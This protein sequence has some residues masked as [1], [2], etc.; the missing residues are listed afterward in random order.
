MTGSLAVVLKGYPRLSETFIA[1]ELRALEIAG[2]RLTLFPMRQPHDGTTHPIHAEIEA[3]VRYLP[4]YLHDA[5]LRMMRSLW[6]ARRLPGFRSALAHLVSDLRHDL[7]R[8]RLRRFGQGAVLA[9][10]LPPD[11]T[12]IYAHFIH[13]PASV[14][15]YASLITG[16]PWMCSAHAKDIWTTPDRDLVQKLSG[17]R[18]TVTCTRSGHARLAALAPDPSRVHLMYHGLDLERF[19]PNPRPGSLRDGTVADDPVRL[20]SVG[21][22]VPKKG[23]DTLVAALARLPDDLHWHFT[24][25]GGGSERDRLIRAAEAAGIASRTTWAGAKD[26]PGVLQAYREADIFALPC[27]VTDSG[28]RDGLPNVLMEAQSQRLACVSTTVGGVAELVLDGETGVL[29]APDDIP[30]LAAALERLI[31]DPVLRR[32][33]GSAGEVRVRQQFNAREQIAVLHD[34]LNDAEPVGNRETRAAE[35]AGAT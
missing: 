3:E 27:R 10:E 35:E 7:S 29:T 30:A 26:Q 11:T 23:L 15:R 2:Q 14:A 19:A 6:R 20:L 28:D 22:A 8:D 1:Q 18:W 34:L 33:L 31:R 32:R 12:A 21:R 5:P 17:A 16:R 25:I 24:H 9:A 13:T 4:E